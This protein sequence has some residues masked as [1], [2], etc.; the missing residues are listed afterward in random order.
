M[1]GSMDIAANKILFS[2]LSPLKEVPFPPSRTKLILV[3]TFIF[4]ESS[5]SRLFLKEYLL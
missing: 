5:K 4:L 2:G 1:V 3:P